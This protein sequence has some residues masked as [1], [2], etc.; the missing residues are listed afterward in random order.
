MT[1]K[2]DERKEMDSEA[3]RVL[4]G[5]GFVSQSNG[6]IA[7]YFYVHPTNIARARDDEYVSPALLRAMAD[8]GYLSPHKVAAVLTVC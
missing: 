8:A 3:L 5:G 4:S 2:T 7:R 6:E 1:K